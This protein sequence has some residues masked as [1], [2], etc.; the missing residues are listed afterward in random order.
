MMVPMMMPANAAQGMPQFGMQAPMGAQFMM[1]QAFMPQ[2]VAAAAPIAT[3]QQQQAQPSQASQQ[4]QQHQQQQVPMAQPQMPT[5][6]APP[7]MMFA[8][9]QGVYPTATMLDHHNANA[10]MA[11]T[12]AQMPFMNFMQPMAQAQPQPVAEATKT[13]GDAQ[14][15]QPQQQPSNNG[16]QGNSSPSAGGS[17]YAHC[18][19]ECFAERTNLRAICHRLH[20][21]IQ[22]PNPSKQKL[23]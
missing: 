8:S 17:N 19:W 12:P 23:L 9:M 4:P 3:P 11:P 13:G 20:P 1:P 18:A 21:S 15:M 10:A 7:Q 2:P 5:M 6:M 16:A 14:A 22:A